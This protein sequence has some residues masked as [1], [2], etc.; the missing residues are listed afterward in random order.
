[1]NLGFIVEG[2]D[3]QAL[4]EIKVNPRKLPIMKLRVLRTIRQVNQE[5]D[6]FLAAIR[7]GDLVQLIKLQHRVHAASLCESL[8][9]TAT[10]RA[11]VGE[12]MTDK[13]GRIRGTAE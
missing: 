1:M 11:L 2:E 10:H 12:R 4:R 5:I 3:E 7:T 13:G 6:D 9:N 8:H